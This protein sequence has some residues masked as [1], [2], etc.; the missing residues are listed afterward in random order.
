MSSRSLHDT[1]SRNID[2]VRIINIR[3]VFPL[4]MLSGSVMFPSE[5]AKKK[6]KNE[7]GFA[8]V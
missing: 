2:N 3:V 6:K 8:H 1:S 4:P 5:D 7:C